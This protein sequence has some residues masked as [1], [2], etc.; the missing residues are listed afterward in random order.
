MYS[1]FAFLNLF[2]VC[3]EHIG[4][5]VYDCT[6]IL[7]TRTLYQHVK[8]VFISGIQEFPDNIKCCKCLSVVEASVNPIAK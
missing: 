7:Y 5:I 3:A 2:F 1:I 8:T 6:F 4:M